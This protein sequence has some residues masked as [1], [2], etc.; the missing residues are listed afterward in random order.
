MVDQ[1][2]SKSSIARHQFPGMNRTMTL[3]PHQKDAVWRCLSSGNTLLAH[4]VGAGIFAVDA[5][6]AKSRSRAWRPTQTPATCHRV[7]TSIQSFDACHQAPVKE[8]GRLCQLEARIHIVS[9]VE[10][11]TESPRCGTR[12]CRRCFLHATEAIAYRRHHRNH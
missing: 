8:L 9:F 6:S 12:R 10:V 11:E 1:K 3:R 2:S 4:A 7:A 5:A